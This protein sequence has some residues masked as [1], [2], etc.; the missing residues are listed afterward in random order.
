MSGPSGEG[1][2]KPASL[3]VARAM[4]LP[5]VDAVMPRTYLSTLVVYY[6]RRTAQRPCSRESGASFLVHPSGQFV[7]NYLDGNSP[8]YRLHL[9][10]WT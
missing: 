7:Y 5:F 1:R 4:A 8:R 9:P 2:N 10:I 6:A 3:G